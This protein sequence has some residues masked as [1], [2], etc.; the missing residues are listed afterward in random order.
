[1]ANTQALCSDP[2]LRSLDGMLPDL[3]ALYKDV[4]SHPELSMQETRTAGLAADRLRAA[5]YEVTTGVG[6]TAGASK[7]LTHGLNPEMAIALGVMTGIG[8]GI[9]FA[10]CCLPRFR[11]CCAP[12]ASGEP[13]QLARLGFARLTPEAGVFL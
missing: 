13:A 12:A 9:W 2:A 4:H 5:G 11:R 10:T 6:K 1:M 7:A 3:E 8:G